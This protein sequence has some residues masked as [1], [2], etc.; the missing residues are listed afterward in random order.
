ML[1]KED[2]LQVRNTYT[3]LIKKELLGPGSEI[4]IPDE[5]HELISTRPEGRYSIGILY[6]HGEKL[7]VDNNCSKEEIVSKDESQDEYAIQIDTSDEIPESDETLT[8]IKSKYDTP[9]EEDNLDDEVSMALQ[10][11]PSS[12]GIT[13]FAIGEVNSIN[14][15]IS[16]ATY[17]GATVPDCKIFYNP[18]SPD[19]FVIPEE[20]AKY[21]D[22]DKSIRVIIKSCG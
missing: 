8:S 13:F 3:E 17:R 12:M 10:N 14:I 18:E 15:Q 21:V 19:N 20:I 7:S 6:P 4:S 11:K 16:F 5:E 2:L 1:K 22:Y 9:S